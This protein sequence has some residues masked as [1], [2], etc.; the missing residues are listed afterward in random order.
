MLW[1]KGQ[2]TDMQGRQVRMMMPS[3]QKLCGITPI[4]TR[5]S[6]LDSWILKHHKKLMGERQYGAR[7]GSRVGRCEKTST[8]PRKPGKRASRTYQG[9]RRCPCTYP[10][11]VALIVYPS[12]Q[13]SSKTIPTCASVDPPRSSD[14]PAC[15]HHSVDSVQAGRGGYGQA[16]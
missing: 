15:T 6:N 11:N 10:T 7:I 3:G 2:Q 14:S 4:P 12:G 1:R 5:T 8:A 13:P 9:D 16:A